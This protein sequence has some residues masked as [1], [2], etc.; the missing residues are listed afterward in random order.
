MASILCVQR[1]T[2]IRTRPVSP[3]D[4]FC[5]WLGRLTTWKSR[6]FE[7]HDVARLEIFV[8]L[9]LDFSTLF[10]WVICPQEHLNFCLFLIHDYD[11]E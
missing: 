9:S 6:F 8:S 1:L 7:L 5:K 2:S 11:D 10:I 4:T 3:F